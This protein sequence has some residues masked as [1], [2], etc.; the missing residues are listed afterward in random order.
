MF[1]AIESFL[2]S[3][4][5]WFS[6]LLTTSSLEYFHLFF[7]IAT[8]LWILRSVRSSF[9]ALILELKDRGVFVGQRKRLGEKAIEAEMRLKEFKKKTFLLE[10]KAI[11]LSGLFANQFALVSANFLAP[12]GLDK[13]DLW[14][15]YFI[16]MLSLSIGLVSIL[17]QPENKVHLILRRLICVLCIIIAIWIAYIIGFVLD[18]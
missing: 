3:S 7:V 17:N 15:A 11:A 14:V 12:F 6:G 9:E 2:E 18:V 13:L 8:G 4:K 16:F 5:S 1:E 10:I